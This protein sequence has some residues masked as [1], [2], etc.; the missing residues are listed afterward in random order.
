MAFSSSRFIFARLDFFS[1]WKSVRVRIRGNSKVFTLSRS[2]LYVRPRVKNKIHA[3]TLCVSLMRLFFFIRVRNEVHCFIYYQIL[4]FPIKIRE[5][6]SPPQLAP[7]A[8][9]SADS[10]PPFAP[11]SGILA[12][13]VCRFSH[14]SLSYLSENRR[15]VRYHRRYCCV[16]LDD[17]SA[18]ELVVCFFS[19]TF[20]L[21]FRDFLQH[22]KSLQHR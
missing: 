11:L 8:A 7:T 14:R 1:T 2:L 12:Q 10:D 22:G 15:V 17:N 19:S 21:Y 16:R 20:F 3:R 9:A 6:S 4:L 5:H 13:N 18:L